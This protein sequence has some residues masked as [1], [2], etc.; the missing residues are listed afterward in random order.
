MSYTPEAWAGEDINELS[1]FRRKVFIKTF[2]QLL[3]HLESDQDTFVTD[4]TFDQYVLGAWEYCE[5]GD[6]GLGRNVSDFQR[7]LVDMTLL[8]DISGQICFQNMLG[9]ML[10]SQVAYDESFLCEEDTGEYLDM[11]SE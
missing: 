5:Q 1:D 6:D 11:E 7:D 2:S 9:S 3:E 10:A 8:D 4:K